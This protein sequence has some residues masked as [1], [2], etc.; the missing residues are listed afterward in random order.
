[1]FVSVDIETGPGFDVTYKI[2]EDLPFEDNEFEAAVSTSCFEHDD[3]FWMTFLD[4]M[5]VL[6]PGGYFYLNAPSNGPFDV[7]PPN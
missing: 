2:G 6:K 3:V 5:S 4:V 1:V 7:P